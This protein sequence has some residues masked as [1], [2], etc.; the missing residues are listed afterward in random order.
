[1]MFIYRDEYYNP[2][3]PENP[4]PSERV[5]EADIIFA[6]HRNGPVGTKVLAFQSRFPKFTSLAREPTVPMPTGSANGEG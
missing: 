2:D 4:T 1:V 6:K 5:G 3:T